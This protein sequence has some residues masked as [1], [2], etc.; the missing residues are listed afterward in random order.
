MKSRGPSQKSRDGEEPQRRSL[1]RIHGVMPVIEALRAG[2][3]AIEHVAIAEGVHHERLHEL[4]ELARNSRV[5]IR[6]V[7]R[8][9]LDRSLGAVTHQG[10]V[11]KIAA[12][13]YADADELLDELA[14]RV[15]TNEPP[16]ALGLDGIE[17]PRNFGA[18]LRTAECAG[19]HGV[20]TTERRAVGLTETVAKTAAGALEY[21]SVARVTN[22]SRLIDQL[23]ER[24][25]WVVGTAGD[26]KR[27]YIEWD[28]TLPTAVF[29]GGEGGGLHRLVRQ[30][31]DE[32]VRIP[33]AGRLDSLNVAVASGVIL[34]EALRCRAEKK[35]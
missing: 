3:R 27:S 32:L 4:L 23:K 14:A 22:L 5:P 7:P 35:Q 31:C 17:D 33:M 21:V 25:I 18:V 11:A 8:A 1:D 30:R 2:R 9:E 13:H 15:G 26:A 34:F 12:A 19:V 16:L 6:R 20:F 28:W 29:L 24:N 10:I